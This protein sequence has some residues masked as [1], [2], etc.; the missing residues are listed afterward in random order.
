MNFAMPS[1]S[2]WCSPNEQPKMRRAKWLTAKIQAAGSCT[3]GALSLK[4]GSAAAATKK[5]LE[6][7]GDGCRDVCIAD[8]D[9]RIFGHAKFDQL[10]VPLR[11]RNAP[12]GPAAVGL[13]ITVSAR[14]EGRRGPPPVPRRSTSPSRLRSLHQ[15][16]LVARCFNYDRR[17]MNPRNRPRGRALW[18]RQHLREPPSFAAFR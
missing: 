17:K 6:L 7:M 11:G 5:A 15:F 9:G 8:P 16:I 14:V 1:R 12:R 18:S 10:S 4:R 2:S 13:L 3:A